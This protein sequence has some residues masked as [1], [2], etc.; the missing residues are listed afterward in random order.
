MLVASG[1]VVFAATWAIC[2]APVVG[3]S[4]YSAMPSSSA[5]TAKLV[6]TDQAPLGSSRTGGPGKASASALTAAPSLGRLEHPAL[7]LK[8]AEAVV[9]DH[10]LRLGHDAGR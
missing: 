9:L 7:E 5:A 2:S 8:G 6:G 3:S 1:S 4:R 10:P